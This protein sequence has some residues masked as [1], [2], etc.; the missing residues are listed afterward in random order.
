MALTLVLSVGL[1]PQLLETRN[2]V[3]QSAGYTLVSA[4]SIQ[5]A[6]ERFPQGDFDL[7]LLCQSVPAQQ[8]NRLVNWIRASGSRVP[9][10]CVSRNL[11]PG[12]AVIGVAVSTEPGSLLQGIRE[13][14]INAE[15]SAVETAAFRDQQEV[16]ATQGKKPPAASGAVQAPNVARAV[17]SLLAAQVGQSWK[18]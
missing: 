18:S 6:V 13:A 15:K 1:D 4:H 17:S 2:M 16:T 12:N 11:D 7:V 5:E 8:K 10:V 14:L 3:L 9:V